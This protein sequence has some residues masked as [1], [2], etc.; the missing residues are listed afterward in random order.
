MIT[1][2]KL[3]E[4]GRLGNQLFQYA[5]VRSV[6]LSKG[7]ELKI[8]DPTNIT[9]QNQKCQLDQFN[10]EVDY[11]DANDLQ[12]L[13]H[14]M[15][16][17]DHSK[18]H[19]AV[20]HAKDNTDFFGYYQNYLYF[21][22]HEKQIKKDLQFNKELQEFASDYV[23]NLKK[24]NQQIVSVHFRRGDNVDGTFGRNS[25]LVEHYFGKNDD[26]FDKESYFGKYFHKAISHFENV[27]F[28]VFSGGSWKGMNNNQ[29]DI[30]WCKQNLKDDRFIFCEGNNDLQDFAIMTNCDHNIISHSTS[31]GYWAAMLNPNPDKIIIAPKNYAIPSD[32]R[33]DQGFYPK[34]WRKI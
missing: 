7:Y 23:N 18:L 20:F 15:I 32:G 1:F 27:K 29:G 19:T 22:K 2:S 21:A 14:K 5:V 17:P 4:Y 9:S 11:L 28:L 33:E 3:G 12:K 24:N 6:S 26:S 30:Q 31:F 25:G 8:P 34:S 16:E 13:K 10:I